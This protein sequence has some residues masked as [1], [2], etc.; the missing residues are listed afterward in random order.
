MLD[1][2]N[3][4]AEREC[5]MSALPA[6]VLEQMKAQRG[7]EFAF[8]QMPAQRTALVI[9]DVTAMFFGSSPQEQAIVE[10]LT[11]LAA[12][13]RSRGGTVLWVRP[14]PF[15][16]HDLM[17]DLMGPKLAALHAEAQKPED[18]R[19]QI[20]AG[21]DVQPGD[22]HTRKVLL[23]AFFPGSSDA[24]ALLR[25]RGIEYVVIG[26]VVTDVCIE[27]SA[28]DAFSC[29][30]RTILLAD[31]TRASSEEAA[32]ATFATFHRRFGDVRD[33]EDVISLLV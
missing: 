22:L 14:A 31:A 32:T 19:N 24:E 15:A 17:R 27:A 21:F 7:R 1:T 23:S 26:G 28:R 2:A 5:W 10:R 33:V 18:P 4:V 11:R 13:L 8:G 3:A 12:D 6:S 20:A 16:R 29:G 9:I 30:F 25:S